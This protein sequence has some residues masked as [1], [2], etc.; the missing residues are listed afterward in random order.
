[1]THARGVAVIGI[2]AAALLLGGVEV[3]RWIEHCPAGEPNAAHLRVEAMNVL[4]GVADPATLAHIDP[5]AIRAHGSSRD[6][7]AR[8]VE[9]T[10]ECCIYGG[11]QTG[12]LTPVSFTG[13]LRGRGKHVV[14]IK[15]KPTPGTA[16]Y[17][18]LRFDRC[19][20]RYRGEW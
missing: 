14:S 11:M 19:G 5:E 16:A 7:L 18:H 13:R 3:K 15:L 17:K 6:E 20:G 1:M 10:P 12:E 2:V 9:K 8:Y 4:I